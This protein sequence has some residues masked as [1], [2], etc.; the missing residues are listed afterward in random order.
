MDYLELFLCHVH[1][2][3]AFDLIHRMYG[4]EFTQHPTGGLY[5]MT[6]FY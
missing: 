4:L 1:Q 2:Y 6:T 3:I 5:L